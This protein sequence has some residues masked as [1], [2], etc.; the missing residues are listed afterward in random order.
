[1]V[2]VRF[3]SIFI[4]DSRFSLIKTQNPANIMKKVEAVIRTA[5]FEQVHAALSKAGIGFMTFMEVKGF[6][7]EQGAT[8]IYR[9]ATYDA[10]FVSRTQIEIVVTDDRV[11]QLV[12]T[13]MKEASTGEVGDGKI[14]IYDVE[15]VIRIRTGE[16]GK[17]AL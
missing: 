8:Q 3:A 16:K 10:G 2:N 17:A 5:K 13:L 14:F 4:D 15:D 7:E 6:G 9:G 12:E 11:D 1:M